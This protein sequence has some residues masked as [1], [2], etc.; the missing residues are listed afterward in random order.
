MGWWR[1]WAGRVFVQQQASQTGQARDSRRQELEAKLRPAVV[2]DDHPSQLGGGEIEIKLLLVHALYDS[3]SAP[4][5]AERDCT[6]WSECATARCCRVSV[7]RRWIAVHKVNIAP[8]AL[9]KCLPI[10]AYPFP[11]R[12][13]SHCQVG[14]IPRSQ[15]RRGGYA[16]NAFPAFT[17]RTT[18]AVR[19][20][21]NPK[22][23]S[24]RLLS[25]SPSLRSA[26]VLLIGHS[27]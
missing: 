18:P 14:S 10:D 1:D 2:P 16:R 6:P 11:N 8:H 24:L 3:A 15:D 25:A 27:R 26:S 9:F 23:L 17:T 20:I 21:Q 13:P 22:S 5:P 12:P 19:M 4:Q 7:C